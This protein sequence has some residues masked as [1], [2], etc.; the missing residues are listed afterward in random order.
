[1]IGQLIILDDSSQVARAAADRFAEIARAA[2]DARGRFSVALAGGSTPKQAYELLASDEYKDQL[3]WSK[4]HIFFGD[5]R[6]V[7]PDDAESNYRMVNEAVLSHVAIPLENIHRMQGVGDAVANARLY[8]DELRTYFNDAEW[9]G[10]DLVLLGMGDDGHTAS[11]FPGSPALAEQQAWVAANWVEKF[12]A[13]RITLTAPAINHAAHVIFLVTGENKADRLAEVLSGGRD[14][15]R[16]PSQL[17]NP[18]NGSL[19]WL[20]DKS[21]SAHLSSRMNE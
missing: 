10:F 17:I 19:E 20:V 4:V 3:D 5:E 12:N 15:G 1:M 11:L 2:I 14:A 6:L 18:L 9:P 7:P 21:A 13:L 8:E 16:L